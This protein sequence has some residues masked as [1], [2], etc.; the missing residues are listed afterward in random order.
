MKT[1]GLL[2]LD[3]PADFVVPD[4]T[5]PGSEEDLLD[6]DSPEFHIDFLGNPP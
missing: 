4:P 2:S 3:L 5:Q 6:P 1:A